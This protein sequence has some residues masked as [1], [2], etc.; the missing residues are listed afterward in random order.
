MYK[1]TLCGKTTV[2]RVV[3]SYNIDICRE[4]TFMY[5][6]LNLLKSKRFYI[7]IICLAFSF[8]LGKGIFDFVMFPDEINIIA[9]K[10]QNF[11]F[12]VPVAATIS[13]VNKADININKQEL[14]E[15]V[16]VDLDKPLCVWA[17]SKCTMN[18][19]LSFLG[20][21]MKDVKVSVVPHQKLIPC[22]KTI[23]V[24]INTDGIMVLALGEVEDSTGDDFLPCDGKIEIGDILLK[25]NGKELSDKNELINVIEN[26]NENIHFEGLRENKSFSADVTP[27]TDKET[28]KK[29][30]GIWVRDSTQGIGTITYI[31][32][33]TNEFAAL[34][35]GIVDVD[36][37]QIMK[38]KDG[39]IMPS[40]VISVKKGASGN[41]GELLGDINKEKVIGSISENNERGIFGKINDNSYIGKELPVAFQNEV[42]EG[43]AYI[44]ANVE[45]DKVEQFKINIESINRYNSDNTKGMIIKMVDKRLLA[46]T[47]GI[48][49]GMS[50]SPIIQ[51]GKLIGAVTHV[52]V[53]DPSRGYG[54]FIENMLIGK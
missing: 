15:S 35:H 24:K 26:S 34:G 28:G 6:F 5:H 1:K 14:S 42:T 23:G 54:T 44:L 40:K 10:E 27:I 31:D 7:I 43:D 8:I 21:P 16:S 4:V 12:N 9:G 53:R 33:Q 36:T 47:N 45:D 2:V 38:V 51:N 3:I 20:I 37:K 25:A 13:R 30:I 18:M 46:K 39:E 19:K 11:Q 41:P 29:K 49:Q 32:P 52:F 22:G 17:D 48:V 50:G